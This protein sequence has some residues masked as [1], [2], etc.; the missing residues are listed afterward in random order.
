MNPHPDGVPDAQA[1]PKEQAKIRKLTKIVVDFMEGPENQ[2]RSPANPEK[3]F[4]VPF[5][6]FASGDD[7]YWENIKTA[8]GQDHWTPLEAFQK[9]RPELSGVKAG[10]VT[11]VA[12][13]C[14]QTSETKS[15][16]KKARGFPAER[17]IRSRYFADSI[18][19]ALCRRAAEFLESEGVPAA[20]PD[21]LES[22]STFPHPKYQIASNWS[23]RH[24]AF[25]AGLGS[26]GLCDGLITRIGKAHRLTSLI[27]LDRYP[28][29]PRPYSDPYEYCLFRSGG[30][31]RKCMERCPVGAITPNG[32]DKTLC[33]AFLDS[34]KP[35]IAEKHPD[36]KGA[37]GCGLCQA[38]V[39]C[40]DRIPVP[41]SP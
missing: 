8:A 34:G 30:G 2:N 21:L 32:H 11:V 39:P 16:Q 9:A 19:P 31:C 25:A 5:L 26:F 24:A 6:G 41:P 27:V 38:G 40:G 12:I 23:H 33:K 13:V 22:F 3:A 7:P 15:D 10:D 20:I 35:V 1:E 14:P 37:Y 29:T 28:P 18:L 4:S 17:W 36:I